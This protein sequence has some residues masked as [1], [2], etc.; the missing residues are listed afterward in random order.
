MQYFTITLLKMRCCW[1]PN[2][3][4]GS[5]PKSESANLIGFVGMISLVFFDITLRTKEVDLALLQWNGLVQDTE[6][7]K[8]DT[9]E[10]GCLGITSREPL[11]SDAS[12]KKLGFKE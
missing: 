10:S 2:L 9:R 6:E 3:R 12:M 7:A 4:V 5:E 8:I 1:S 11:L